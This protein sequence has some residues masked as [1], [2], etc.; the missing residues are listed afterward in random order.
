VKEI[1]IFDLKGRLAHFR[2]YFTNSSSLSYTYPPRTVIIGLVAGLMGDE[3][4]SYYEKFNDSHCKIAVSLRTPVRKI[5][6]TMNYINS[7][8]RYSVDDLLSDNPDIEHVQIPLE[9]ICPV[10]DLEI[11]YRIYISC[12]SV[13]Q[14]LKV[15]LENNLF[16]YPPYLGITEFLGEIEYISEGTINEIPFEKP[17]KLNSVCRKNAI[18]DRGLK[19]EDADAQYLFE[20][21]PADFSGKR[22][23]TRYEEYIFEKNG[24]SIVASLKE[25]AYQVSYNGQSE[26]ILFM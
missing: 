20:K 12:E 5:M 23:V 15:R 22:E 9:V 7:N 11:S 3:R 21:M 1:L 26:N 18:V 6:Q 17:V 16:V 10:D 14:K 19:F 2:K 4:D 24:K 25:P 13:H 8:K